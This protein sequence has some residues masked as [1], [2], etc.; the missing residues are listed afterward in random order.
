M[1][2]TLAL[3][4]CHCCSDLTMTG[5]RKIKARVRFVMHVCQGEAA[6]SWECT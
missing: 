2:T 1:H 3:F 5:L 4:A 6:G